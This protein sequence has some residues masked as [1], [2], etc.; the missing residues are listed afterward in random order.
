MEVAAWFAG[1]EHSDSPPCVC[2]VIGAFLRS[3]N[4]SLPDDETRTRL[5]L[6]LVKKIVGTKADAKIEFARAMLCVDWFIRECAP[7][8]IEMLPTLKHHADTLRAAKP[9]QNYKDLD[10]VLSPLRAAEK[11]ASAAWSAAESAAES[12]ARSA[13]RS[14]AWSALKPTTE[15]LQV[16]AVA[17]VERMVAVK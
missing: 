1:K 8:W 16:S 12:A 13:A 17:L 5:L 10:L 11:D 15:W 7:T 9:I 4:D 2:P 6:P 14:A 3:W